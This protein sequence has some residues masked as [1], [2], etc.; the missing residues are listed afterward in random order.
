[1]NMKKLKTIGAAFAVLSL[2]GFAQAQVTT[3]T[4]TSV[5]TTIPVGSPAG[6]SSSTD[7]TGV[8]GTISSVSVNLDITGGFNGDFYAYLSGPADTFT[9][10]LN[11]VGV[12]AE[13]GGN[14]AGYSDTG[15]NV[16][17]SDSA[18]DNIHYYQNDTPSYDVSSGQLLGTWAPDGR[19]IDPES[20]PT[21]FDS[22]STAADLS[23]LVS[24][25]PNGA[26]TLFVSDL[27]DGSGPGT[28]VSWGLS[29]VT[30]PEPQTWVMVIGGVG[31]LLALNRRRK[32]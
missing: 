31:M 5:N 4:S 21:A 9:V 16:T 19:N 10:L 23:S 32:P 27:S 29:V 6:L 30:V 28:L 24:T 22:A 25:S 11:R 26:W 17:F 7:I 1:M 8:S 3:V 2:T 13:D 20:A 14:A 18:A 12:T 15:F